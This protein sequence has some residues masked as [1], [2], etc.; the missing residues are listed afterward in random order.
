[1]YVFYKSRDFSIYNLIALIV[2][3]IETSQNRL[4]TLNLSLNSKL[5]IESIEKRLN[6]FTH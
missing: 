1:M 5:L 3:K 6:E 4:K 2:I